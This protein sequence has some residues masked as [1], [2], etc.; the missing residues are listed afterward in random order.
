MSDGLKMSEAVVMPKR[1]KI[2]DFLVK[3]FNIRQMPFKRPNGSVDASKIGVY[4]GNGITVEIRVCTIHI[5]TNEV[6]S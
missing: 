1:Q 4:Q 6:V 3:E 2:I 5:N